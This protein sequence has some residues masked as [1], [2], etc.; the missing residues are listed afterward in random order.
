MTE[1]EKRTELFV[2]TRKTGELACEICADLRHATRSARQPRKQ[3]KEIPARPA[4][5]LTAPGFR[6]IG[7]V[8]L[9]E[10][11]RFKPGA[12]E[13]Q[14]CALFALGDLETAI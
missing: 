6:A 7:A 2:A 13:R 1:S 9:N 10:S 5:K 8:M 3:G 12:I 14:P 11:G 4:A